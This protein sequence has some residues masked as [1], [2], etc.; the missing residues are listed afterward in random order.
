[1]GSRSILRG[2]SFARKTPQR[3]APPIATSSYT[4]P[5]GW[6]FLF[7]DADR[8]SYADPEDPKIQYFFFRASLPEARSRLGAA[9]ASLRRSAYLWSRFQALLELE[10]ELARRES[11]YVELDLEE[12]LRMGE[13]G[14]E[15]ERQILSAPKKLP[16]LA[17]AA[18]RG[19]EPEAIAL[20][21]ALAQVSGMTLSGEA[22]EDH[23]A[24]AHDLVFLRVSGPEELCRRWVRGEPAS[25]G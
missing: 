23:A 25:G 9:I 18:A 13:P 16:A 2:T 12:I 24:W 4:V 7:E 15:F 19:D 22:E 6:M 10:S 8:I 17:A 11:P 20:A 3:Q 21:N 1:V 14:D 5:I